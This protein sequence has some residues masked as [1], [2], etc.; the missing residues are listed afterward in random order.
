MNKAHTPQQP[1]L[2]CNV[3]PGASSRVLPAFSTLGAS[4]LAALYPLPNV[5]AQ[6]ASEAEDE[7]FVMEEILVTATKRTLN[8]QD[9]PQSIVS[10]NTGDI[11]RINFKSMEDYVKALPSVALTNSMPGRNSVVMRGISTGNA[12]YRTESQVA[13][14]LDEQPI[15]SIS[16]QPEVR[17]IDIARIEVLPGP[18][19][20]LFGSSSQTGTMRIITNKPTTDEFYGQASGT[21]A[22][23]DGGDPSWDFNG[24]I[25]IPVSDTLAF[26]AI[27][28]YSHDGG[29]VDVVPSD[30]F[31]PPEHGSPGNNDAIVDNNQ[32]TYD[33]YG[34][35][36][37]ALWLPSDKWEVTA[38][39]IGQ[40]S[41]ADGAWETDPYI[42]D[43]KLIKFFDEYRDD[44]WW[45]TS[46]TIRGDLGFAEFVSTTSYF[47]R[48]S[49]YEWDNMAYNQWQT[50]YYAGFNERYNF[51][52]EYGTIF[53]DQW[54][55]RF[56]QEF[57]LTSLSESKLQWMVG[58]FYDDVY[59]EW[60]FGAQIPNLTK[61]TAWE[62]INYY[63]CYY[64][65]NYD[66]APCPVPET[67]I[68][69]WNNYRRTIKQTAVFGEVSYNFTD[70]LMANVGAR[71]FE[72]DKDEFQQYYVPYLV[73]PPGSYGLG[74]GLTES[75]GT[76]S[77]TIYKV[78]LQYD[79]DDNR[80]IYGLI[81]EGFRLGGSNNPR[82]I[83]SNPNVPK[84][85][86]PD[87][88]TNYEIG[89][90]STWMEGRLT[91]NASLFLMEWEG[92]QINSRIGEKFWQRG[93][94]NG[95]TG[96]TAGAE[97]N[98]SFYITPNWMIEGSLFLADAEY[99]ADTFRPC[100]G[101]DPDDCEPT[102]WI[103]DGQDMPGSPDTKAWAAVEYTKPGAWGLGGE[104]WFRYD[105]SYQS[106]TYDDL[107]TAA[108]NDPVGLIPSWSTANFQVGWASESEWT[109]TLFVRNVWN[110]T[111]INSLQSSTFYYDFFGQPGDSW[112]RTL[113]K[114]RTISFNVTKRF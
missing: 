43:Y 12:E 94:W 25:N 40:F 5:Y 22:T 97:I 55:D 100:T 79:I 102:L 109:Y 78:G 85:Y 39:L 32:N 104:M 80:M 34:G 6:S 8:L 45:Q 27:G 26:R 30:T 29:Y 71:W 64:A 73:P 74:E 96:E 86:A 76:D 95:E 54:Q 72:F 28:F 60:E 77:D 111:G 42:G 38:S 70:K 14:Y 84:E 57:R 16:Q 61:T 107:E 48:E 106:E 7:N 50:A 56:A 58:A 88:L 62:A 90:K 108:A 31:R 44:D 93:T 46:L 65:A 92:I 11:E 67:N 21:L 68:N 83:A 59:D 33:V 23:T 103:E 99:T 15:T 20:T 17:M 13:V 91:L 81:S 10:F 9:V 105:T 51:D 114:P 113:Q 87:K 82:V 69:Y 63:A 53:N 49:A 24:H 2:L 36:L 1:V 52:Y 98:G 47:D 41:E 110:D 3:Q 19:G 35:R 101:N 89:L 66:A 37:H 112:L 75:Q 18:Q 4:I